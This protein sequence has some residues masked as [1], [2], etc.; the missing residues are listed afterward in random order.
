M[1][2]AVLDKAIYEIDA[3][4]NGGVEEGVEVPAFLVERM[5]EMREIL[6]KLIACGGAA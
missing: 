5:A 6:R 1:N 3:V 2:D 4:M